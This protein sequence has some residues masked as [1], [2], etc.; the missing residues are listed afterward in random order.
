MGDATLELGDL[1]G[2]AAAY[3]R[4]QAAA[5]SSAA[6]VRLGRL[7]FIEGRTKDALAD[8]KAAL[9]L[10]ID[11]GLAGN[12]LAWY[13]YQLGELSLATGDRAAA[14]AAFDAALADDPHFYLARGG[15][16]RIAA[17][18]G[19][20]DD[21]IADLDAAVAAVPLPDLLA[22]RAD[23][24]DLRG[25]VGD[26]RRATDDRAT[27]LLIGQLSGE[28][29]G[30]YDRT[31]SLYLATTGIDVAKALRLAQAEIAIRKDVYGYDALGWAL[32]ANGRAAEADAALTQALAVGTK[33][34]RLDYHAGM[35]AAAVGDR[36]RARRLLEAALALDP[37]FDPTS[38][39]RAR[40]TL[41]DLR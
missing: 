39:A 15:R 21:A 9:R 14:A 41:E 24:Y 19:R 37:T 2:A 28:A 12:A 36:E 34:A 3:D 1:D 33:D 17:A 27:I 11:E 7:A 5:D 35:A 4:L 30:V 6:R 20:L 26:A 29:A 8:S 32:L 25:A 22:R 31:L 10:A 38:V 16:A 18:D 23:L 40:A 13:R